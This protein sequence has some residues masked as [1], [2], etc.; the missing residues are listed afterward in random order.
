MVVG[1]ADTRELLA[2]RRVGLE[3]RATV[4]LRLPTHN[5]AGVALTRAAVYLM[6]DSYL[7]LDQQYDIV[8]QDGGRAAGAAG[9]EAAGSWQVLLP[10]GGVAGSG[11]GVARA[12]G[13]G[14]RGAGREAPVEA[15][16]NGTAST[17]VSAVGGAPGGSGAGGGG[18]TAGGGSRAP[19]GSGGGVAVSSRLVGEEEGSAGL[20]FTVRGRELVVESDEEDGA[21]AGGPGGA[22]GAGGEVE[23]LPQR[24]AR[25]RRGGAG[26]GGGGGAAQGPGVYDDEPGCG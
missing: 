25:R 20:G 6:S 17:A 4:R 15:A 16:A 11:A 21:G 14:R 3:A 1:D 5:G 8:L 9:Q 10:P 24:G 7:G 18:G 23:A 26:G 22:V 12:G 19:G 13:R 2:L